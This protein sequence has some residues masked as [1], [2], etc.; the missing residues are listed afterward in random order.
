MILLYGDSVKL[1]NL[2]P[3]IAQ[4]DIDG[5]FIGRGAWQAI[6]FCNILLVINQQNECYDKRLK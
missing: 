3:L 1:E 6:A 4:L 2:T 5:L